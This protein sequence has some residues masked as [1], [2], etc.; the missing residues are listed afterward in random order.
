MTNEEKIKQLREIIYRQLSPLIDRDYVYLDLPYHN[1]I[2]D[3]LIWAGTKAFLKQFPYKC[4]YSTNFVNYDES[5]MNNTSLILLHGGGNFGDLYS[6]F[7][8]FRKFVIRTCPKQNIIILPQTV[9][10]LDEK[11]LFEDSSFYEHYP[12]VTIC[13][14]DKVSYTLLQRYFSH[15]KIILV[16]DMAFCMRGIINNADYK[17]GES[18]TLYLRRTDNEYVDSSFIIPGN[19]EIHDWPTFDK[20]PEI[21]KMNRVLW[22]I[23]TKCASLLNMQINAVIDDFIWQYVLLPYNVRTGIHFLNMYDRLYTTRLHAAILGILLHK[24]NINLLDNSYGKLRSFYKTWLGDLSTVK[25]I[26]E[27]NEASEIENICLESA[28]QNARD[29]KAI[30]VDK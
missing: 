22:K 19:A 14:R 15:N 17:C 23:T 18:R 9:Y 4:L 6:C 10:Y 16:P 28:L 13:A 21:Y 5:R 27:I 26:G 11:H 8:D 1:N 20:F 7:N 24:E 25:Y 30:E 2:G 29:N 12:N 3:S